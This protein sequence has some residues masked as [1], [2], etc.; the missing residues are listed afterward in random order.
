LLGKIMWYNIPSITIAGWPLFVSVCVTSMTDTKQLNVLLSSYIKA[1]KYS[2][3]YVLKPE[4][5]C[6]LPVYHTYYRY[7]HVFQ[8]AEKVYQL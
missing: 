8:F 3:P 5:F 6:W 2:S 4:Q 1:R 7:L